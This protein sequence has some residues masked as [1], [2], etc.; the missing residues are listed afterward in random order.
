MANG[1]RTRES[2]VL[3]RS[4]EYLG[5]DQDKRCVLVQ[6]VH[7]VMYQTKD[8]IHLRLRLMVQVQ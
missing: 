1:I 7:P 3:I 6:C 4:R 2:E 5:P 8:P